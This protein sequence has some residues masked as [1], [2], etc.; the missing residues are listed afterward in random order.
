MNLVRQ[1]RERL[2]Y[3]QKEFALKTGLSLRTIQR[4]EKSFVPPKGHT[5]K[6]VAEALQLESSFVLDHFVSIDNTE[7]N[8][9]SDKRSLK[10]INLA[11]LGFFI[12][13]FGNIILTMIVWLK[14]RKSKNVDKVGRK[15]INFQLIWA[16]LLCIGLSISPIIS[17]IPFL[18]FYVLFLAVIIN[19][20]VVVY[21]ARKIQLG[22]YEFLDLPIQLI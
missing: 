12:F 10:Y 4:V 18:I 1:N 21:C 17:F 11:I 20:F 5:L 16:V 8:E 15:I 9:I 22:Q 2:G 6:V 3:T 13:P 14:H 19:I 7:E